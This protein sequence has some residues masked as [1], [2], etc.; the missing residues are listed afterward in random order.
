MTATET[1]SGVLVQYGQHPKVLPGTPCDGCGSTEGRRVADHCHVHGWVRGTAC[2]SCNRWMLLIDRRVA[3]KVGGTLLAALLALRNRC[4]E[5]DPITASDLG[6]TPVVNPAEKIDT[7]QVRVDGA[8]VR[9]LAERAALTE[10]D[11]I[12]KRARVELERWQGVLAAELRRI[13][14]TLSQARY[15]AKSL[16]E[17]ASGSYPTTCGQ[18]WVK[19]HEAFCADRKAGRAPRVDERRL[20]DYLAALGPAADL[21]LQDAIG[22]LLTRCL[23]PDAHG[24]ARVGLHVTDGD[25]EVL[26]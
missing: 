1:E 4:P 19:C 6:A 20:L 10:T 12:H 22:H 16:A 3:P 7:L 14:L 2:P 24:F 13:Q 21:A 18:V 8:L 23:E 26:L 15:I 5:C 11:S 9:W 17:P 25:L